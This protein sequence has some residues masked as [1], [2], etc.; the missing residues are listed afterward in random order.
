MV[1][2]ELQLV[3]DLDERLAGQQGQRV[4]RHGHKVLRR[5]A[6]QQRRAQTPHHGRRV[7]VV[8]H[9]P[10]RRTVKTNVQSKFNRGFFLA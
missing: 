5:V 1:E 7:R 9:V 3:G 10:G 4:Q 6:G 8:V 2:E